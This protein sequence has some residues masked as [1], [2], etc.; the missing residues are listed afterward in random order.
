MSTVAERTAYLNNPYYNIKDK[1]LGDYSPFYATIGVCTFLIVSILLLNFII[2]CCTK[3]KGYWQD[4]HTG[5]RWIISIYTSTP[6][7]QPPLDL[8]ELDYQEK[9][10]P[11]NYYQQDIEASRVPTSYSYYEAQRSQQFQQQL[12]QQPQEYVELQ[13]RESDI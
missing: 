13:T 12:Q 4:R 7:K 5:N 3:Y 10:P 9:N 11:S 2:G 6:H 1:L 8:T